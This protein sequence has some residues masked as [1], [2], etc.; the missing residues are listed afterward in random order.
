MTM[1]IELIRK[2]D[3]FAGL[4]T[5]HLA[6][7]ASI[8]T[9]QEVGRG[10]ILFDEGDTGSGIYVVGSGKVRISKM[11]PGIGE[12]ALA[13][14]STGAYF[15][16][17][18]YIDRDLARAARATIHERAV[19]YSFGYHELDDLMGSDRD[20]ALAITTSMLRT[21]SRRLRSTNDKLTAMF[22]MAQFS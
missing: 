5:L 18:E 2:I 6:H 19:L 17:M 13:I 8:A 12:E 7:L 15:G 14:L 16:E 11:V 3:L 1:D 20:L 22:A 9:E 4:D 10:E 21:F